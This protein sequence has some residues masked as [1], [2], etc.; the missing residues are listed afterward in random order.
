M[1]IVIREYEP[2]D[3]NDLLNLYEKDGDFFMSI[4]SLKRCRKGDGYAEHFVKEITDDITKKEGKIYV[5]ETEGKVV[6]VIAGSISYL[7][8]D[9]E[10][11]DTK[12]GRVTELFIE[13]NYRGQHI[14]S[15]LM[16]KIETYFKEQNCNIINIEVFAENPNAQ[17]FYDTH[18]YKPRNIDLIKV[19]K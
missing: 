5:A 8:S 1:N 4:D 17:K 18:G 15:Q 7:E 16:Q 3:R 13:Q 10:S 6:G 2:S 9:V 12:R 14:G 11:I 19:L